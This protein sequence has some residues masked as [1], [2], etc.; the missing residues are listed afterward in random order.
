M[1][2]NW[3]DLTWSSI[4]VVWRAGDV[5]RIRC[6]DP[7][8]AK[9]SVIQE[10][11]DT[12]W[13]TRYPN[14]VKETQYVEYM[15]YLHCIYG[16]VHCNGEIHR[17]LK[18]WDMWLA[19]RLHCESSSSTL[20]NTFDTTL[21]LSVSLLSFQSVNNLI[22]TVSLEFSPPPGRCPAAMGGPSCLYN[23]WVVPY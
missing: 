2:V 6:G 10:Y 18:H 3:A 8:G 21:L 19:L 14:N 9:I 4:S 23:N 15:I 20:Y 1:N 13:N 7:C 22:Y 11:D 5:S 17:G 12:E 16:C